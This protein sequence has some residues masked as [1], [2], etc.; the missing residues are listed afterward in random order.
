M[1]Q[2]NLL[3]PEMKKRER[4]PLAVFLPF[5]ACLVITLTVAAATA[6]V[7]FD[8][9]ADATNRR[10]QMESL[11]AQKQPQLKYEKDL[12]TEETTYRQRADTIRNIADSRIL[13]TRRLDEL[14]DLVE[15]G[16]DEGYLIWLTS[17]KTT[18]AAQNGRV[19]RGPKGP[20][21]SGQLSMKGFALAET[22]PLHS[23][24][25]FHARVKQSRMFR[26]GYNDIGKPKGK[27]NVF[28]D[29]RFPSKGWS[30][31]LPMTMAHPRVRTK[32]T[33]E[34]RQAIEVAS[35]TAAHPMNKGQ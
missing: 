22:D 19:L 2:I 24:N 11:V 3:P 28:T 20:E 13:M 18:P 17:L 31:D 9:L 32:R 35:T 12:L 10:V 8:Q 27:V 34:E 6:W 4:T 21:S 15:A 33:G 5:I 16:K 7:R 14:F 23:Y 1:T 29:G 30:I 25:R 26:L